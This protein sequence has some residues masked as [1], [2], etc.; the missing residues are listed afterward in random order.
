MIQPAAIFA[1]LTALNQLVSS[2]FTSLATACCN[3]S[4]ALLREL[5]GFSFQFVS[6]AGVPRRG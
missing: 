1:L 3:R 5:C 6:P 4:F 2:N